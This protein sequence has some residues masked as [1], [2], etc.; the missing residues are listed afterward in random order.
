MSD[1]E[2]IQ[3]AAVKMGLGTGHL[4]YDENPALQ[5]FFLEIRGAYLDRPGIE[6][7]TLRIAF[8]SAQAAS[9]GNILL[10]ASPT[11]PTP[12][13]QVA[14]TVPAPDQGETNA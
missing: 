6:D 1:S 8:D 10:E 4:S 7:V 11:M 13:Q 3:V 9:L 2:I 5:V 12:M 14:A